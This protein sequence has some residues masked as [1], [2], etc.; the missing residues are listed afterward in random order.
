LEVL[1][2][3]QLFFFCGQELV[4]NVFCISWGKAVVIFSHVLLDNL[5]GLLF[6]NGSPHI[7]ALLLTHV[8]NQNPMNHFNYVATP[9]LKDQLPSLNF[10]LLYCL[11]MFL[12]YG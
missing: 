10:H 12:A 7:N 5:K 2:E 9:F 11:N 1:S 6:V 3:F 4:Q 8:F